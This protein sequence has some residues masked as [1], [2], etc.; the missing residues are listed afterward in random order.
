MCSKNTSNGCLSAS[1]IVSIHENSH[2]HAPSL[3]SFLALSLA[4]WLGVGEPEQRA[5]F[6]DTTSQSKGFPGGSAV[7]NLPA[8][9]RDMDSIPALERSSLVILA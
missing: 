8:N 4:P 3:V 6:K 5:S 7:K 2:Q 1:W 9:A